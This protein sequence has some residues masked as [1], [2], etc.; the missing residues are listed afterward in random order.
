M[1]RLCNLKSEA[2][3]DGSGGSVQPGRLRL[4]FTSAAA[5]QK[6][7]RKCRTQKK[8]EKCRG[9]HLPV[10]RAG[11]GQ[12]AAA[13]ALD[14]DQTQLAAELLAVQALEGFGARAV[15][16]A[17]T[18]VHAVG[19]AVGA[20]AVDAH[21][22]RTAVAAAAAAEGAAAGVA[23]QGPAAESAAAAVLAERAHGFVGRVHRAAAA[24]GAAKC[25]AGVGAGCHLP[26]RR[27][28]AGGGGSGQRRK[29]QGRKA[30]GM[31]PQRRMLRRRRLPRR[32]LLVRMP[33]G[34]LVK[35]DAPAV[36]ACCMGGPRCAAAP[37][38]LEGVLRCLYSV[39]R[40]RRARLLLRLL[41]RRRHV[42]VVV[43]KLVVQLVVGALLLLRLGRAGG[44]REGILQMT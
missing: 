39:R 43:V 37:A 41:R 40:R 17:A 32:L 20:E 33:R 25:T 1:A 34:G 10:G 15:V 24:H 27:A 3:A 13:R 42:D 28:A 30:V 4:L 14:A 36:A 11:R 16:Q 19:A 9:L 6:T 2:A 38:G 12:H 21:G 5:A 31:V 22:G 29:A 23:A 35:G 18:T 8:Q 7:S 26:S 44:I